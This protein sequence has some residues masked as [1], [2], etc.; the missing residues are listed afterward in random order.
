MKAII[1]L[2]LFALAVFAWCPW[3]NEKNAKEAIVRQFDTTFRD[4]KPIYS[5]ACKLTSLT[6]MKK[7]WFGY[8]AKAKYDCEITGAGESVVTYTFYN[9]VLGVPTQ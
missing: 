1:I 2:S 4:T 5:G 3:V 7:V 8:D 6:E 9:G